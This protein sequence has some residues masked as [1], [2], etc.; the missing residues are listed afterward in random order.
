MPTCKDCK[1][2]CKRG[3]EYRG[4]WRCDRCHEQHLRQETRQENDEIKERWWRERD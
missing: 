3:Y 1:Q 2:E 4:K